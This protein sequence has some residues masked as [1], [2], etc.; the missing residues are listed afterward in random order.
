MVLKAVR[1][2]SPTHV[3]TLPKHQHRTK[4]YCL[5]HKNSPEHSSAICL[6]RQNEVGIAHSSGNNCNPAAGQPFLSTSWTE[7]FRL[8]MSTCVDLYIPLRWGVKAAQ[9]T[10]REYNE[11]CVYLHRLLTYR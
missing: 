10:I 5:P 3:S 6:I 1:L 8:T 7:V 2:E 11:N 9:V 4:L